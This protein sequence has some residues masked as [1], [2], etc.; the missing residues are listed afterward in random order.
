MPGTVFRP[1]CLLMVIIDRK[2]N[3]LLEETFRKHS[4]DHTLCCLAEGTA[5]HEILDYLGLDI[6]HKEVIVTPVPCEDA[7]RIIETIA[8]D[9]EL[10]QP[11]NG[12]AFT[13]PVSGITG[14]LAMDIMTR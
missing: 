4:L 3:Q 5:N 9:M 7:D 6:T 1:I 13:L 12:I 10:D 14:A 8:H 11:G 2:R